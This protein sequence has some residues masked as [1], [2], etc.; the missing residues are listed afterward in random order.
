MRFPPQKHCVWRS[1]RRGVRKKT[2]LFFFYPQCSCAGSSYWDQR[3]TCLF[4]ELKEEKVFS[5]LLSFSPTPPPRTLGALC[6]PL[7][8]VD[9]Q[10]QKRATIIIL[11]HNTKYCTRRAVG[12]PSVAM[13]TSSLSPRLE[14]WSSPSSYRESNINK[15]LAIR[16]T[17]SEITQLCPNSQ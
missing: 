10:K 17:R 15:T 7:F 12:N 2:F 8:G 5:P 13:I 16:L 1:L 4:R 9:C 6:H 11:Y 14:S 3:P